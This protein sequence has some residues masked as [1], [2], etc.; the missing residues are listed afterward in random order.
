MPPMTQQS[1]LAPISSVPAP[2]N[3]NFTSA[4]TLGPAPAPTAAPS[5][6]FGGVA[7]AGQ[8][9]VPSAPTAPT[10]SAGGTAPSVATSTP[11]APPST[12]PA[13][14]GTAPGGG[15]SSQG[16]TA[17]GAAPATNRGPERPSQ[18]GRGD[19]GGG[20]ITFSLPRTPR[21]ADRD[22]EER[23]ETDIAPDPTPLLAPSII[24]PTPAEILLANSR[25]T[26]PD[27]LRLERAQ[28]SDQTLA[29]RLSQ[30]LFFG[31][32]QAAQDGEVDA[33]LAFQQRLPASALSTLAGVQVAQVLG[34]YIAALGIANPIASVGLQV[35]LGATVSR[36]TLPPSLLVTDKMW[37][38]IFGQELQMPNP[39]LWTPENALDMIPGITSTL[40]GLGTKLGVYQLLAGTVLAGLAG[41]LAMGA[42]VAAATATFI[43]TRLAM[44]HHFDPDDQ[45]SVEAY[46]ERL[47]PEM[48]QQ[49]LDRFDLLAVLEEYR[50]QQAAQAEAWQRLQETG[51]P[52]APHP[53]GESGTLDLAT[54]AEAVRR[55][56]G[57]EAKPDLSDERLADGP[58]EPDTAQPFDL[59]AVVGAL[60][61]MAEEEAVVAAG[62]DGDDGPGPTMAV[63]QTQPSTVRSAAAEVAAPADSQTSGV[64]SAAEPVFAH[65]PS[66]QDGRGGGA[67]EVV[68]ADTGGIPPWCWCLLFGNH[69]GDGDELPLACR[70][71]GTLETVD[72][73]EG[74]VIISEEVAAA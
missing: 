36:L 60:T 63:A 57:E 44:S 1:T 40:A 45:E 65:R 70:T 25:D 27:L 21:R 29:G 4:P 73:G 41:P 48:A 20:A 14:G 10:V 7:S 23:S 38:E 39:G 35:L 26:N 74:E 67:P 34:P 52:S 50:E 13:P 32:P 18:D 47:T 15:Q 59:A 28:P 51:E 53:A 58:V 5:P 30:E 46:L 2:A 8:P 72:A 43:H 11:T 6:S 49:M 42:A 31:N 12:S 64:E 17:A 69:G 61:S 3:P 62:P 71:P 16:S 55:Y 33:A 9:S 37:E 56:L 68:I 24:S 54:A 22:D 66:D 19:E